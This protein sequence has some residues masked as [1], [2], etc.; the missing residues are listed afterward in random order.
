MLHGHDLLGALRPLHP[1]PADIS[2]G[3]NLFF[4]IALG[5]A[6]A[7]L[8]AELWAVIK[9]RRQSVRRMALDA[10]KSSRVESPE[11]R[12]LCQ[13]K[14]LRDIVRQLDG[15]VAASL[16]GDAWLQHL[17]TTFRTDFF[18]I[19]DGRQFVESLYRPSPQPNPDAMDNQLGI[20]I[21]QIRR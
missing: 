20:F 14:L 19:G 15:S 1:P 9:R 10:L 2:F 3:S 4:A 6:A 7:F 8:V 17:D 5:F 21:S 11:H 12:L 16:S 18:T 13:A